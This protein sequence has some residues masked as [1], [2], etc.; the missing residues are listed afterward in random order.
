MI[1]RTTS[2]SQATNSQALSKNTKKLNSAVNPSGDRATLEQ[3]AQ[4][5]NEQAQILAT[6]VESRLDMP[7]DEISVESQSNTKMLLD[8]TA[9]I[10]AIAADIS[11]YLNPEEG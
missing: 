7:I 9:D 10:Y 3:V 1:T 6:T 5:L 8:W 4:V 2:R 11:E